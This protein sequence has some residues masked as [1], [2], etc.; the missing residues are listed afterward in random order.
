VIQSVETVGDIPFDDPGRISP[1]M[2]D[3]PQGG[4]TS[5]SLP[6][7]VRVWA[8]LN[9]VIGVQDQPNHFRYQFVTPD[10]HIHSTLPLLATLL[11]N[12]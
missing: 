4:V 6:K 3:F 5:S 9:V 10:G 2:I 8:E 12:G 7:S 11:R 1:G